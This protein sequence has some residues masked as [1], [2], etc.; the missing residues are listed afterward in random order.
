MYAKHQ[1]TFNFG[2]TYDYEM[3][4]DL[5]IDCLIFANLVSKVLR[6]LKGKMSLKDKSRSAAVA[7]Q[8]WI[9]YKIPR[10]VGLRLMH[11]ELKPNLGKL[12]YNF[13]L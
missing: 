2:Q 12:N 1:F 6:Q 7:R 11:S 8:L 4:R 10:P 13:R 9:L 5:A 3:S